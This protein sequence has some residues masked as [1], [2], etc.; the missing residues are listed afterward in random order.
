MAAATGPVRYL[1]LRRETP[2]AG[3]DLKG[4][5]PA[6]PQVGA[7]DVI[8][9]AVQLVAAEDGWRAEPLQRVPAEA[10]VPENALVLTRDTEFGFVGGRPTDVTVALLGVRVEEIA[11]KEAG[12]LTHVVVARPATSGRQPGQPTV[13][14]ASAL[15][16]TDY[17]ER[18]GRTEATLGLRLSPS[19]LAHLPPWMPDAA[20]EAVASLAVDGA[21][22]SPRARHL[23]T[24]EVRAGR[25]SLHGRAELASNEEA[26]VRELEAT[27]GVVDVV[28]HLLVDESLTD[29]VERALAEQGITGVTVLAEHG[30]VSLH[31]VAKD[32]AM[33]RK[34][35]DIAARTP[36]VRGVVNRIEVGASV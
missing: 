16:V 29:I 17:V 9:S 14:P 13:V 20:V 6:L 18:R 1:F 33:R 15:V 26:A 24:L 25:V 31:G 3:G 36:G 19:D 23:I 11:P 4:W 2:G 22:L 32:T 35:E 7:E 8:C 12:H 10:E 5:P 34:A 30:L 21:V 28:S 27:P